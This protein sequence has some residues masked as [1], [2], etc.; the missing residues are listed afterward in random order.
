MLPCVAITRSTARRAEFGNRWLAVSLLAV[1]G[2]CSDPVE[3]PPVVEACSTPGCRPPAVGQSQTSG[4]Q[5]SSTTGSPGDS[6]TLSG[7]VRL[8]QDD[9]FSLERSQPYQDP[10]AVFSLDAQNRVV[11]GAYDGSQFTLPGLLASES[12]TVLVVPENGQGSAL[13]TLLQVDARQSVEVSLPLVHADV[14]AE[15]FSSLSSPTTVDEAQAQLVYL[16]LDASLVPISGVRVSV[17]EA[18]F[19]AY[20]SGATY[21]DL[22][23]ETSARG[24]VVAGNVPAAAFPGSGIRVSLSGAVVGQLVLSMVRG[25]V[26]YSVFVAD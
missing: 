24:L 18:Q 1:S 25:A 12:T 23:D 4:G 11:S 2:A 6:I 10:A 9:T 5:G 19:V 7:D 22:L 17:P 15:I 26:S 13:P 3:R 20:A 16:F 21:S 14:L 8:F